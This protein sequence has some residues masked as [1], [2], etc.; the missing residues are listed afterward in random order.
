MSSNS[1]E[2]K[3]EA[4]V[5]ADATTSTADTEL[6]AAQGVYDMSKLKVVSF[7]FNRFI[8]EYWLFLFHLK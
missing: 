8:N 3:L 7:C 5:N 2:N 4:G 1:N 6:L